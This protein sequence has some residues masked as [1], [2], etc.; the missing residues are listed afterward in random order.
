[1]SSADDAD[2][3]AVLE[4][5]RAVRRERLGDLTDRT[6]R[7]DIP[8]HEL[9]GIDAFRR[10]ATPGTMKVL[11][12]TDPPVLVVDDDAD[13]RMMLQTCLELSG[14]PCVVAADGRQGL[15]ALQRHHPCVVMLDLTMPI[16]NGWEFRAEQQK[17]DDRALA[18]VPIIVVTAWANAQEHATALGAD[19]LLTKPVDVDRMVAI[20]REY[21]SQTAR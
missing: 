3:E 8:P 7:G 20:A 18:S 5:T 2:W 19:G 10:A 15:A 9:R 4:T 1:M 11:T 21:R 13:T 12:R 6:P 14:I 17:L 16:M